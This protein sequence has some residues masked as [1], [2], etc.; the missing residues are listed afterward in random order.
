MAKY[1]FPSSFLLFLGNWIG[2]ITLNWYVFS[3]YHNVIYL[4]LINFFRLILILILS[5]WAGNLADKY[6]KATLIKI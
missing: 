6:N 4:G 5:L 1:F 2:Q 3:L